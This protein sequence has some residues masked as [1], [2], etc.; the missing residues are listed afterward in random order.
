MA[1]TAAQRKWR[2]KHR[3]VKS[4]LNVMTRR[5]VHG[6]LEDIARTFALRGKGEAVTFAG[7]A[8]KAL[9]QRAEYDG[10]AA[11]MLDQFAESYRR[12]RDLY[13]A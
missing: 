9:M 2:D 11:R 1:A 5:L 7:F 8:V 3:Y 4:Q 6:Y 13:S 10:A 12:D